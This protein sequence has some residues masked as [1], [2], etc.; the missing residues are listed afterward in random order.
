MLTVVEDTVERPW[1]IS[2]DA[3]LQEYSDSR[4]RYEKWEWEL[5]VLSACRCNGPPPLASAL[6]V[7]LQENH[8]DSPKKAIS[9]QFEPIVS[10]EIG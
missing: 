2:R 6:L 7:W 9:K 5:E 4:G 3:G 10:E 8:T 1:R